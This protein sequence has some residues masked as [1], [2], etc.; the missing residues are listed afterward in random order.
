MKKIFIIFCTTISFYLTKAQ[1]IVLPYTPGITQEGV[2]YYL[3]QTHLN[4]TVTATR[5]TKIPGSLNAYASR[6]LRLNDVTKEKETIW[7][8]DKIDIEPYGVPDT[9]KVFSIL[10]KKATIAPL[11]SLTKNG[12]ILSINTITTEDT[13]KKV[14]T[15]DKIEKFTLNPRDY[16]T[17]EILMAG[18]KEK[19]AELTAT[20]I[21]DIRESRSQLSKGEADNM[22]KD[23]E[24]LKLMIKQLN[25][26]E[27]ALL[28]LFKG[29]WETE[30]KTFTL[31]YAPT[32]N[33]KKA[34]LFRFSDAFGVVDKDNLAG[35]P[36]YIDITDQKS[37]PTEKAEG[38]K[39][40]IDEQAVRYN[41]PSNVAVKIYTRDKKFVEENIPMGQFGKVEILSSELFNKRTSTKVQYFQSTGGIKNIS[42]ENITK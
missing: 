4:I 37:I 1:T 21:Y 25:T 18:S 31:T 13:Q 7:T 42:E 19:M 26:Q 28:Q 10:I 17:Q 20:E 5:V 27:E 12:I 36:V 23:G 14:P 22:P 16:M 30:T 15:I 34:I 40:K 6:Y 8:I 9:S 11:V 24:Q 3:P 39:K 32:K 33:G 38:K 41:V 2:T 35:E 29:T